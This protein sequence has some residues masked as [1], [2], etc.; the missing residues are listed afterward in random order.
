MLKILSKG[1][2][3]QKENKN[4]KNNKKYSRKKNFN[5]SMDIIKKN[6]DFNSTINNNTNKLVVINNKQ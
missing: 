3:V 5:K 4:Y 1:S 2:F 6:K